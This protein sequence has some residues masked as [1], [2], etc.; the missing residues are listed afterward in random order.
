MIWFCGK[1][2][3]SQNPMTLNCDLDLEFNKN[4]SKGSGDLLV[5]MKFKDKPQ[6]LEV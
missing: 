5:D 2:T 3:F 4:S 1:I 6:D